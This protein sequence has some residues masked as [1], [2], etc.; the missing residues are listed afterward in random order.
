[1]TKPPSINFKQAAI[2]RALDWTVDTTCQFRPHSTSPIQC[3]ER[4]TWRL[5]CQKCP[6]G[7]DLCPQ[8]AT[9][10]GSWRR[11]WI[12][13]GDYQCGTCGLSGLFGHVFTLEQLGQPT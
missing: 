8:H 3:A 1:M 6:A 5:R 10:Y 4:A 13:P 7:F 11:I 12:A 2:L 9:R